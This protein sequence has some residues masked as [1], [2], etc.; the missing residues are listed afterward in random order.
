MLVYVL[1][2]LHKR[3][4]TLTHHPHLLSLQQLLDLAHCISRLSLDE[5]HVWPRHNI[6]VK[7]SRVNGDD[8]IATGTCKV[9]R[10]SPRTR[11]YVYGPP[12]LLLLLLLT[13]AV[14]RW[15]LVVLAL[16]AA[17][18]AKLMHAA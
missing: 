9:R 1:T 15:L 5:V 11:P 17:S 18:V 6:R 14:L 10:P 13:Q 2:R 4:V 8:S 3:D 12:L 7:L 16:T